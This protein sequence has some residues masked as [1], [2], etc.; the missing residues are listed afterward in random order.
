MHLTKCSSVHWLQPR[1]HA[2]FQRHSRECP[3]LR[4]MT[5]SEPCYACLQGGAIAFKWC[6]IVGSCRVQSRHALLCA[7]TSWNECNNAATTVTIRAMMDG[8]LN[9]RTKP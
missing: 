8:G 9:L 5:A 4:I 2:I 7:A 3:H 6:P 1:N